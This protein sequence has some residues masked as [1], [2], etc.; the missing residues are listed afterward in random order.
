MYDWRACVISSDLQP[1]TRHVLLTL[2]L[3]MDIWGK[4]CYPT[5]SQIVYETGLGRSTVISHL[6]KAE[7][8]GWLVKKAHGFAGQ[9]WRN[10]E[11]E[12]GKP[13]GVSAVPWSA[14]NKQINLKK[15]GPAPEKNNDKGGPAPVEGGPANGNKVVPQLDPSSS[16]SNP[17]SSSFKEDKSKTPPEEFIQACISAY[18]EH[19]PAPNHPAVYS[20][21]TTQKRAKNLTAIWQ[22][23]SIARNA[24]FWMT[25]FDAIARTDWMVGKKHMRDGGQF[26]ANLEY[27][28]RRDVFVNI[29]ERE[30]SGGDQ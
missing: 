5:I 10:H 27:A 15:G 22:E 12:C 17:L 16:V 14:A 6:Q 18:H 7:D 9:K 30:L 2:S 25:Y 8:L 1:T 23:Q 13:E 21:N 4:S 3:H 24:G 28:T 29:V 11:Y 26:F 20:W 19:L